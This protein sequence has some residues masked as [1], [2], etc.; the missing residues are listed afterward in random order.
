[1][2]IDAY[3][4]WGE[5]QMAGRHYM[6]LIRTTVIIAPDGTIA[7]IVTV[8]RVKDHAADMLARVRELIAAS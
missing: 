7:D 4:V 2:A 5:K 8:K 6:G 3:G 1:M